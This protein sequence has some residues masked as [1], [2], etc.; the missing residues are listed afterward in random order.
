MRLA[1]WFTPP[2]VVRVGVRYS[3]LV[4]LHDSAMGEDVLRRNDDGW[5]EASLDVMPIHDSP[6]LD[7]LRLRS[8]DRM[9]KFPS[10]AAEDLTRMPIRTIRMNPN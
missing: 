5:P 7:Q 6:N 1:P 4:R 2:V 10:R 8:G 9:A 3:I